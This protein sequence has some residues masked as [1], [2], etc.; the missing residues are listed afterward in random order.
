VQ[1]S[2]AITEA[3]AAQRGAR[4]KRA[5]AGVG[6]AGFG[7]RRA[8]RDWQRRNS[9]RLTRA[10]RGRAGGVEQTREQ[11]ASQAAL[12]RSSRR[13][14]ARAEEDRCGSV[15]AKD[16]RCNQD[17]TRAENARGSAVHGWS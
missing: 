10:L 17:V 14:S 8:A 12:E 6:C 11:H 1:A 9:Q 15:R 5:R 16:G 4:R 3:A 2:G 13:G 7:R